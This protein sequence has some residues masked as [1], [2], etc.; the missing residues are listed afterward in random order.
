M[1][2]HSKRINA[3]R[4]L[5]EGSNQLA[6]RGDW[7]LGRDYRVPIRIG[8]WPPVGRVG[9]ATGSPSCGR[10]SAKFFPLVLVVG[11]ALAGV[12]PA[13]A[14]PARLVHTFPD[15]GYNGVRFSKDGRHLMLYSGIDGV[16]LYD[17]AGWKKLHT[18]GLE[19][20]ERPIISAEFHPDG[21]TLATGN[22]FN[23]VH[24]WDVATGKSVADWEA[25]KGSAGNTVWALNYS[26]DGKALI[27]NGGFVCDPAGGKLTL[28]LDVGGAF[29]QPRYSPDGKHLAGI[30]S[31][32]AAG[33]WDVETGKSIG[34]VRH[35]RGDAVQGLA[36]SPDGKTLATAGA[37]RAVRLW[38]FPSLKPIHALE[39][40][41]L[42]TGNLKGAGPVVFSPDGK[43]LAVGDGDGNVHLWDVAAKKEAG[44]WRAYNF[45]VRVLVWSPDGTTLVTSGGEVKVWELAKAKKP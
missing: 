28:G 7:F 21:K 17:P 2:G 1:A 26:P 33:V 35:G 43:M 13:Q 12:Q 8:L 18:F 30:V 45:A 34:S 27:V 16:R 24:L 4:L 38:E 32:S 15:S 6:R 44:M 10:Q 41:G 40:I 9:C 23:R 36:F 22:G 3:M 31:R 25:P 19:R 5:Q 37:D 20:G 39:P 42:L 11:L 14:Q 29:E